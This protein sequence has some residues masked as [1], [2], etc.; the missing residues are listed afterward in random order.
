M[1]SNPP[2]PPLVKG[3][4]CEG[5]VPDP[6]VPGPKWQQG[7]EVRG[8]GRFLE[9]LRGEERGQAAEKTGEGRGEG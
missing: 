4:V 5:G 8:S 6:K 1:D 3:T 7:G 9:E 2:A